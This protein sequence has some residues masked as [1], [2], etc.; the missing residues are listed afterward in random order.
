M[1]PL[2][3]VLVTLTAALVIG[4][5]VLPAFGQA[6]EALLRFVHVVPG[7]ASIDVYV[8]GQLAVREL[9]YGS[10]SAYIEAS[11]GEN[12]IVVTQAGVTTPL[13]Q[14]TIASAP[15]TAT[16][17]IASS[18]QTLRFTAYSED[19]NPLPF[20]KTRFTVVHAVEGAGAVD[21]VL[22]DGRVVIPSLGYN[23]PFGTFD[24][25]ANIY[26]FGVVPAGG[27]LDNPILPATSFALNTNTSY[28]IVVY[29]TANQPGFLTLS[30]PTRAEVA[31]GFVRIGHGIPEAPAVDIYINGTLAAPSLAF[32]QITEYLAI[33]IGTYSVAVRLP[34]ADSDLLTGTLSVTRD[35]YI[36]AFALG[37]ADAPALDVFPDPTVGI[38]AGVSALT[39]INRLTSG[40]A[41]ASLDETILIS[42]V[43]A[44]DVGTA[45]L[46]SGIAAISVAA[47]TGTT[48]AEVTLDLPSG[49]YGGVH[50]TILVSGDEPQIV[51]FKPASIAQTIVSAPG[52]E[53]AP[54]VVSVPTSIP[55]A[56]VEPTQVVLSLI[57]I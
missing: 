56:A 48:T 19:L 29:G 27:T 31:G 39:L 38:S 43:P 40:T 45:L 15:G 17:L 7:A 35:T 52:S 28:I 26:S 25:E 34:G 46:R 51:V 24:V 3:F 9:R 18:T 14:Q 37:T 30:A 57:H 33:P 4:L 20:G 11:A 8:N 53:A 36:S 54:A 55:T 50:Y 1:K 41:S 42:G 10:A 47:D 6:D 49:V 32:G 12:A 2:R 23:Q 44:G 16:T 13:W 5:G 21:V 22:G